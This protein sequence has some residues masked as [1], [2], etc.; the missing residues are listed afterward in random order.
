MQFASA[1]TRSIPARADR[2]ALGELASLAYRLGRTRATGVLALYPPRRAL[3]EQARPTVLLLRRGHVITVTRATTARLSRRQRSLPPSVGA[4]TALGL[5][6]RGAARSLAIL[7]AERELYYTFDSGLAAYPSGAVER[8]FAL[9]QWA[10]SHIESHFNTAAAQ[11]LVTELA[12]TRIAAVR[13]LAPD[14]ALCDATDL[15]IL[16][17]MRAPRQLE[18]IAVMARTPRY[19]LLSFLHFLRAVNGL[20]VITA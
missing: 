12:G 5:L 2:L 13:Y 14:S 8:Q 17:A 18:Q 16:D 1:I 3:G 19:R 10:R 4:G 7:A 9:A 6:D 15:R 20:T 11:R